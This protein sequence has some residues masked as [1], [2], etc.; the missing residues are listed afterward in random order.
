LDTDQAKRWLLQAQVSSE[1]GET[2]LRDILA[3]LNLDRLSWSGLPQKSAFHSVLQSPDLLK[4]LD[5]HWQQDIAT[6]WK[7]RYK[8]FQQDRKRFERL[9]HEANAGTLQGDSAARYIKLAKRFLDKASVGSACLAVY[10]SNLNNAGLCMLCGEELLASELSEA[11]YA[12]LQRACE[13]EPGLSSRAK[14]IMK[15]HQDAWL[16]EQ[17]ASGKQAY[18]V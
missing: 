11:G 16:Y 6:D 14:A 12:A 7:R 1:S 5:K 18:G 8:R 2:G 10:H 17:H 3:S 4:R 13:L 9:H 15:A